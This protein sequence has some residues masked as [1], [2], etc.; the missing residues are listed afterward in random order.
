MFRVSEGNHIIHVPKHKRTKDG[1]AMLGMDPEMQKEMAE[2]RPAFAN[3]DEDK[4]FIK[5]DGHGFP[6]GTIGKQVVAFF[7]EELCEQGLCWSHSLAQVHLHSNVWA[8]WRHRRADCGEGDISWGGNQTEVLCK[9]WLHLDS[10]KG[11]ASYSLC[12]F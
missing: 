5:D 8:G 7:W 1:P 4:L 11:N 2:I 9:N 12:H 3:P 10:L 6:E